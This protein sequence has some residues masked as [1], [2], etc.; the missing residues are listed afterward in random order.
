MPAEL[1]VVIP[2]YNEAQIIE[3]V[4]RDW[5]QTLEELG[6][7]F[8]IHLYNDGSTDNSRAIIDRLAADTRIIAHH[9]FNVGHGPTLR[10]AYLETTESAWLL[11]L[12][13]DNEIRSDQF[14]H[15]WQNRNQADLVIGRRIPHSSPFYRLL[16]SKGARFL[17]RSFYGN[18]VKDVNIPFR[19]FRVCKFRPIFEKLPP[20]LFS[21]NVILSGVASLAHL[22]V[23]EVSV[24][25]FF[26]TTGTTSL[27]RWTLLRSISLSVWQSLYYRFT[28]NWLR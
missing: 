18:K 17:I 4:V 19:L 6:I 26:R 2:V 14:L 7:T 25:H 3:T 9:Q 5:I 1:K 12:D 11:Q 10:K 28:I 21:P 8:N 16:L 13:G 24:D 23:Q 20:S 22:R 15:L 27:L